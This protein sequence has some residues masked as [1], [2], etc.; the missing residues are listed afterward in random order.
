MKLSHLLPIT[1]IVAGC[2]TTPVPPSTPLPSGRLNFSVAKPIDDCIAWV[3]IVLEHPYGDGLTLQMMRPDSCADSLGDFIHKQ[4]LQRRGHIVF[5]PW[6]K[7]PP[8]IRNRVLDVLVTRWV[9]GEQEVL[10]W[11]K[12]LTGKQKETLLLRIDELDRSGPL[13]RKK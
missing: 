8:G 11:G 1:A 13:E 3:D 10:V 4:K 6:A 12:P 7:L 5:A 9:S 2:S